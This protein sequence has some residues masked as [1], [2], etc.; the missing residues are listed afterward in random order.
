M[1]TGFDSA[2]CPSKTCSSEVNVS[3]SLPGNLLVIS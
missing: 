2:Y 1:A 3:S